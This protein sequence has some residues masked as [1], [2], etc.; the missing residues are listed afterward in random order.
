MPAFRLHA[1]GGEDGRDRVRK[2]REEGSAGERERPARPGHHPE[3]GRCRRRPRDRH[4]PRPPPRR[5]KNLIAFLRGRLDEKGEDHALI[6][7]NGVGYLVF[8]S[9]K[10]LGQLPEIG[11]PLK[12][13]TH[14]VH[15][16]DA[17]ILYGFKTLEEKQ[18][19]LLLIGVSGVGSKT[20][21]SLLSSLEPGQIGAAALSE[22]PEALICPGIG[23][24]IA[25]RIAL[26]LKEKLKDFETLFPEEGD[27]HE[28][29]EALL[30]LGYSPEEVY[31]F[32]ASLPTGIEVEEAIRLALEGLRA[33]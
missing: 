15:R 20:A 21:L 16:E 9:Q 25:A 32:L 28:V 5:E 3:A 7:V 23:K 24:K 2:G 4:L 29:E 14:L 19:F 10:T 11:S 33:K 13:F 1:D 17:M 30:A 8:L 22:R 6:D 27:R 26:E 12:I 31:S 18:M